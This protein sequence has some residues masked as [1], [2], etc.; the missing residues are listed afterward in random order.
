[1][2]STG[3]P[4]EICNH[5]LFLVKD[6]DWNKFVEQIILAS[7]NNNDMGPE[8]YKHFYWGYDT[9]QAAEFIESYA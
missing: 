6:G 2:G 4:A 9:K 1:K 7:N 3:V 8:F 5:K